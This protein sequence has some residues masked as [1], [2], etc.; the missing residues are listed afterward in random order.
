MKRKL[1]E[2]LR[3]LAQQII[4]EDKNFKTSELKNSIQDLYKQVIILEYL[5]NQIQQTHEEPAKE[6]LD[7]KSFREENWF[8]EPEPVPQP[9]HEEDIVEPLMEKIKDI[10]AQMPEKSE[11]IDELLDTILP[12]QEEK[13]EKNTALEPIEEKP[14]A[15]TE[16]KHTKNEL[17][18][19][20]SAYQQMPEFERKTPTLFSDTIES[21]QPS[22]KNIIES[23]PKS[24]ND[25]LNRGLNIG[26]NDRL[27]FI[28][29]LFDGHAEDYTRVLSQIN[30]MESFEAAEVFIV[31]NVKPDYQNWE[32]KEEYS[33]RFMNIVEKRFS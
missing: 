17:E 22:K 25:T 3:L 29:H 31:E 30:T 13:E 26:L 2:Q 9:A 1:H 32:N 5:E 15:Q 24:L 11:Q 18:E 21:P 23:R 4:E 14:V 12:S 20:A 7:S 27:A 6:S 33:N 8:V 19:F 10:V 28:K 16:P